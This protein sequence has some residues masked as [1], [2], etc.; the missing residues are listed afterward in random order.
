MQ[1]LAP[2]SFPSEDNGWLT[3]IPKATGSCQQPEIVK[4][5]HVFTKVDTCCLP[6]VEK[7]KH[8]VLP[9]S[10][11]EQGTSPLPV[12]LDKRQ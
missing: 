11:L 8:P 12:N 10:L 1:C 9:A 4:F 7:A 2:D 6:V 5:T 3:S